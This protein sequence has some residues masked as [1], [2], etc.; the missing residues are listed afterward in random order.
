MEENNINGM[1]E[2]IEEI[3]EEES[4]EAPMTRRQYTKQQNM[5]YTIISIGLFFLLYFAVKGVMGAVNRPYHILAWA[6]STT[7]ISANRAF[8]ISS[9]S[10][11]QG[12]VFESARLDKDVSGYTLKIFFSGIE[13]E[14]IFSESGMN[15]E[16]GDVEEDIRIEFYPYK[17][18]PDYAEY[19]YAD[20]YVNID[21]P[22][23]AVYLFE[24]EGKLYAGYSEYS[25]SMSDQVSDLFAGQE[26]IY[27]DN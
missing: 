25:T 21:D 1:D 13:D 20:K 2:E 26:R 19:V 14:E 8:E 12:Y 10:T 17:E 4:A 16:Y 6:D 27:T 18:N 22:S 15:F 23:G 11:D 24:W 9:I 5:L 3:T 7:E